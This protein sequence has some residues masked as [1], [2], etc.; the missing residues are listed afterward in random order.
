[1]NEEN[2]RQGE[3]E[4]FLAEEE[5]LKYLQEDVFDDDE[6][7]GKSQKKSDPVLKIAAF[8]TALA[9]TLMVAFP[10][11]QAAKTKHPPAEL[12]RESSRLRKELDVKLL[13]ATVKIQVSTGK[14][15][16]TFGIGEK[17]GTGFNIDSRGIIITN[18]HVIEDANKITVIFPDGKIY[19]AKGWNSKPEYDL[20]VIELDKNNLPSIPLNLDKLP[21]PGENL[22]VIGN[23]LGFNNLAIKG[24][25]EEYIFLQGKPSPVLCMDL[26]VYP[27]NSGS[28]VFDTDGKVVGVVFGYLEQK[29]NEQIRPYGL[30][31]PI[32]E[33]IDLL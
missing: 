1:M 23:P 10:I 13:N 20:A 16:I 12:F 32:K 2:R 15:N 7:N 21:A 14:S 4:P 9:F 17:V 30:A 33:V 26:L 8:V 24:R 27:G 11:Y 19:N 3:V 31:M 18:H 29:E 28:P 22:L 25:L 6:G 5:I